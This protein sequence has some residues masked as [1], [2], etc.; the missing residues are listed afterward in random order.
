M[1]RLEKGFKSN[2]GSREL[3][4]HIRIAHSLLVIVRYQTLLFR[5]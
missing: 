5:V 2:L 1:Y 3:Q 4:D